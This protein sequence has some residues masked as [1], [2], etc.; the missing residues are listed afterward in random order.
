MLLK[1]KFYFVEK[2]LKDKEIRYKIVYELSRK[3]D[4]V[5]VVIEEKPKYLKVITSYKT[6]KKVKDKWKKESKLATK[7]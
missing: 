3:Y 1:K 2:Q 5:I 4:F 7:K 6:S